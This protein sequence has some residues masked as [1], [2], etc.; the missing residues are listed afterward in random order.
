MADEAGGG[1]KGKVENPGMQAGI[2]FVC[3]LYALYWIFLK[4]KE[5]NDYLGREVANP[6]LAFVPVLNILALWNLCGALQEAQQKAGVEAKG[7]AMI[8]FLSCF[9]CAPY[10]IFRVQNKLNEIWEK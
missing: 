6:I 4:V 9:I 10:G 2:S 3:F 1:A 7:E 5:L 8:D